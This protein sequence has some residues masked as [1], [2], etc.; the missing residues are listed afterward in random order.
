MRYND[1]ME[2]SHIDGFNRREGKRGF[3]IAFSLDRF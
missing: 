3:T 1:E 2:E